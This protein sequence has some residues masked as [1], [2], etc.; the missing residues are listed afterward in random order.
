MNKKNIILVL[1][2]QEILLY[3]YFET[4]KYINKFQVVTIV[5]R[6]KSKFNNL[7]QKYKIK[8]VYNSIN[9]MVDYECLEVIIVLVSYQSVFE[10]TKLI[11]SRQKPLLIEKPPELSI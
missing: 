4:L 1:L 2:V 6:N 7:A 3:K 9:E 5:S 10:V 8:S 11:L